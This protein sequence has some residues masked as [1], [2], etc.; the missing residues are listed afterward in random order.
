[1]GQGKRRQLARRQEITS[2]LLATFGTRP[3]AKIENWSLQIC[4][5][6]LKTPCSITNDKFSILNRL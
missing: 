4:H 3:F 6:Q 5:W 2:D 1:M